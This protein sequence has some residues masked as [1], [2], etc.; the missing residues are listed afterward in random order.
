M[1]RYEKPSQA[2]LPDA[3][4]SDLLLL[5]TQ[6]LLRFLSLPHVGDPGHTNVVIENNKIDAV[7][8]MTPAVQIEQ[9]LVRLKPLGRT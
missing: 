3:L 5:A 2:L 4:L 9:A 1:S 7:A 6:S 8:R